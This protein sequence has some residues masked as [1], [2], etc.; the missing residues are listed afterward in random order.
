MDVPVPNIPN[1]LSFWGFLAILI[2]I[3]LKDVIKFIIDSRK[4]KAK[5]QA[6]VEEK[7]KLDTILSHTINQ[8]HEYRKVNEQVLSVL[9]IVAEQWAPEITEKQAL[10]VIDIK[11]DLTA[12]Q[13]YDFMVD[14]IKKKNNAVQPMES[15]FNDIISFCHNAY[16][17][18][19]ATLRIF[20][21]KKQ[22]LSHLLKEEWENQ[23]ATSLIRL[24]SLNTSDMLMNDAVR[25]FLD[26]YFESV[27][28]TMKSGL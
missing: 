10:S 13:L 4:N 26:T 21:Y 25:N 17:K 8:A 1:L 14:T 23:V 16:A 15:T 19:Y 3:I 24:I 12:L 5:A 27:K 18:D 7:T 9:Q 22:A 2:A 6:E 20:S 11:F 28:L